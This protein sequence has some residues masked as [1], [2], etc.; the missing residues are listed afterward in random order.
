[1][2]FREFKDNF[3]P[4]EYINENPQVVTG[5]AVAILVIALIAIAVQ[6]A[7]EQYDVPTQ[8]YYYDTVTKEVF[9]DDIAKIAPFT[10]S[11]GNAS[12]RV[13]VFSCGTCDDEASRFNAYFEKYTEEAKKAMEEDP[14]SEEAIEVMMV[15]RLV[16]KDG[17]EWVIA[18][19]EEGFAMMEEIACP[20]GTSES[21]H[22]CSP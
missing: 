16:S 5:A 18:D 14:E 17:T 3:K 13:H 8:A 19:G 1:M 12:V 6:L 2:D 11:N 7:P 22:Y 9:V 10:N 20:D 21:L 4:R 15:G